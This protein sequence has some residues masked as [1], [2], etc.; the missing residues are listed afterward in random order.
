MTIRQDIL[1]VI[2]EVVD[3]RPDQTFTPM[4]IV[5]VLL[6]RGVPYKELSIRSCITNGMCATAPDPSGRRSC[7]LE[8]VGRGRY[9][10]RS[11]STGV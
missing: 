3:G 4:E 6:T 8:R 7:D 10:L 9:R 2:P 1:S 11:R 5:A